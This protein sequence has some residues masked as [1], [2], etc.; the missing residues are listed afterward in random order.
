M[1]FNSVVRKRNTFKVQQFED[2]VLLWQFSS[3]WLELQLILYISIQDFKEFKWRPQR[4]H[5]IYSKNNN[6]TFKNTSRPPHGYLKTTVTLIN[7]LL[8]LIQKIIHQNKSNWIQW[9]STNLLTLDLLISSKVKMYQVNP[10]PCC[11]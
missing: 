9:I 8:R 3:Y 6:G 11:I 5:Q 7:D 2:F 10:S 1:E 4:L